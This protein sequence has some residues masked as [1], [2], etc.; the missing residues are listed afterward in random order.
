MGAEVAVA[1]WTPGDL[2]LKSRLDLA[3]NVWKVWSPKMEKW[4]IFY[5]L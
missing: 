2:A 3:G 4:A 5:A 1:G